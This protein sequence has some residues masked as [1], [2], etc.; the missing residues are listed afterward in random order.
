MQHIVAG[1]ARYFIAPALGAVLAAAP[2]LAAQ[3]QWQALPDRERVSISLLSNEGAPG[4]VGRIAPNGV[5]VPF[6]EVPGNLHVASPPAGARIFQG[7]QQQGRS[8]VLVTQTPE[9]GYMVSRQTPTELVVD[10]FPNP[11]GARWK[12]TAKAPTT[13]LPPDQGL[14]P[15]SPPDAA[16][17]TLAEDPQNTGRPAV[18]APRAAPPPLVSPYD[19]PDAAGGKQAP[20]MQPA[21]PE[22]AP[23]QNTPAVSA[24][25][26]PTA[27][28][29][30][31]KPVAVVLPGTPEYASAAVASSGAPSAR[32]ITPD[33]ASGAIDDAHTRSAGAPPSAAPS[34]PASEPRPLLDTRAQTAERSAPLPQP[35]PVAAPSPP[36][37]PPAQAEPVRNAPVQATQAEQPARSAPVPVAQSAQPASS[38]PVAGYVPPGVGTRTEGM[39]YG[40]TVNTGGLDSIPTLPA[41]AQPQVNAQTQASP[42]PQANVQPSV[43]PRNAV[44]PQTEQASPTARGTQPARQ[45]S[46]TPAAS[47]Q[48][49][50]RN[51]TAV[52]YVDKDGNPV[53][54]PPDPKILLP[55][56][57][58]HLGANEFPQ[59]LEKAE[60]LL[61]HGNLD[62][63]EREEALHVRAEMIFAINKDN[64]N[65]HY[66]DI[67]DATIQAINYNQKSLRNAGALL[68]L[69]YLNLRMK[70][71]PE[72]EAR[73]NI[74]RRQFPDDE[75]V[76]LSY[77][78]WGDYHFQ[79]NELQRAA[80]EFQYM[81]E[82]Y[83]N[84][85]YT[86]EG[87]LGLARA[88]YRLGYYQQSFNVVDYIEKRWERFYIEYPPFLNMMG[89]VA[90]RLNN[91][92]YA[93]KHYWLYVNLEPQGDEADIILTRIGDIYSMRGEKKAGKEM[94][95]ESIRRF[96][97]KDGALVAMMRLAEDS[98][99]DD[100]SIAGMFSVFDGPFSLAPVEVY[101]TIIAK[102]PQSALVPIAEIK[103]AMWHLWKREF[104]E[105]LDMIAVFLKKYPQHELAPKANEIA[106]QTFA[107]LAAE[108]VAE[109]RYGRMRDIWERY[110][111]VHGQE[112]ILPAESRIALGVSYWKDG[113]PD[114]ALKTVEPFF[115]GRKVPQYSEMALSLV[116]SIYLE[117]DQ[118][119]AIREVAKRVDLWELSPESQQQLNYALALAAENLNE[120]DVASP[121]W[122][123]L[124]DGG[125]L[126]ESQMAYAAFFL[127]RDAE[128]QRELE[129]A[130]GLGK[131]ALN[132]LMTS[133]ERNPNEADLGK[134]RS[135]LSSLV[136][137]AET[138][139]RL[140]EA[141][142]FATQ[143]LQYLPDNDGERAAVQYRMARIYRKQG[144]LDAWK[145]AL[146]DIA[147]KNPGTVYGQLANSE[148]KAAEIAEDAARYSPTGRI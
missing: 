78:Y 41:G 126:P 111:I 47:T 23:A 134:I 94:Y 108:S 43:Q 22:Q 112:E 68:R 48:P 125:T 32:P 104:I 109:G 58:R 73:F 84:S 10:F 93:L 6:S 7:T 143:Y 25:G 101:R 61:Q 83:P 69:G 67:S 70:N 81:L 128:K 148:L 38:Q 144:N 115:L 33:A 14:A 45:E 92:D 105:T 74:L 103:L 106:L 77:Y 80:D 122:Q 46:A 54:P 15:I 117:H 102:H 17:Q 118:W 72:A 133:A 97:D 100:P 52:V 42:P 135:Q 63:A 13:E 139:G 28:P 1:I 55:E 121:I 2:C 142:G 59:A 132:R 53:P 123:K 24:S 96:P 137:V 82:H 30:Q 36:L 140:R 141:L 26:R 129:K 119:K 4:T 88:F 127:A 131:E 60:D 8:L 107:V 37:T 9:F 40:G 91:F 86:R 89:D 114:D 3:L 5:I 39:T 31:Q 65:Q 130:Y 11:L 71:I 66:Q 50:T 57:R 146:T 64:L 19:A 90:F 29:D 44:Q 56:I 79:R 145:T 110:P 113:K 49:G 136:D 124:Y 98:V 27:A 12:P 18:Q 62:P 34:P 51:A 138:A 16:N 35:V 95:N 99:N 87:A 75:N 76:P 20:P 120:G 116:L 21:S 85:R 147:A